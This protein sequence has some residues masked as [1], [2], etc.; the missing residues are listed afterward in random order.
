MNFCTQDLY[1]GYLKFLDNKATLISSPLHFTLLKIA[2][3]TKL[4]KHPTAAKVHQ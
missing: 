1:K 2:A 3:V 4:S